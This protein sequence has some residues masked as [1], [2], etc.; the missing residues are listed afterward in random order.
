MMPGIR[1]MHF[2]RRWFPSSTVS[3]VFEPLVADWQR[4][5]KEA[6]PTG[7]RWIDVKGR[8]AFATT[9]VM[10]APRVA[11]TGDTLRARLLIVAGTFWLATAIPLTLPFALEGVPVASLWLLLPAHLTLMLPFAILPAIDAMRGNGDGPA[12]ADCRGALVLVVVAVCGV[13]AGQGWVTPAA[14]LHF[15]NQVA[16]EFAGRPVVVPPGLREMTTSALLAGDVANI[17]ALYGVPRVRELNMRLSLALLPAVLAWLRWRSLSRLRQRSW[18]VAKSCLMA[19]AATAGFVA[20]MPIG[21][22]LERVFLAPGF[23]P[24]LALSRTR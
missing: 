6:T 16:S 4:E 19:L 10:M 17:P 21:P 23:G 22:A 14:N 13:T 2:A 15:R 7:R 3:S 11:L 24:T 12:A 5:W 9:L 20:V 18:P 8:V 1:L